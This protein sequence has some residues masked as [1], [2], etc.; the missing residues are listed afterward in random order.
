MA[1]RGVGGATDRNSRGN[2]ELS[3]SIHTGCAGNS[4]LSSSI[5]TSS[6]L[7]WFVHYCRFKMNRRAKCTVSQRNLAL[8]T[9]RKARDREGSREEEIRKDIGTHEIM[10]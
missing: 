10:G 1:A 2:S 4:E 6:V 5:H 8:C 7:H 9:A 3:S